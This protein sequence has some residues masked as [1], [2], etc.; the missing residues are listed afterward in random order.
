LTFHVIAAVHKRL[1]VIIFLVAFRDYR[2]GDLIYGERAVFGA[3]LAEVG[4]VV[5]LCVIYHPRG[6]GIGGASDERLLTFYHRYSVS[7]LG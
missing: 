2:N 3:H 4:Y 1:A 5:A 6:N 7:T